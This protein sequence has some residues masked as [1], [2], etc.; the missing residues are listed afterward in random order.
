MTRYGKPVIHGHNCTVIRG[1][2]R[3]TTVMDYAC[4]DIT[5]SKYLYVHRGHNHTAIHGSMWDTAHPE[6]KKTPTVVG[7]SRSLLGDEPR[8]VA[9]P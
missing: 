3:N 4:A 6:H 7:V 5:G 8:A 1:S 2:L 9:I